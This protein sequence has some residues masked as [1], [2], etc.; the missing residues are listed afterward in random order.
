MGPRS[1]T[2]GPEQRQSPGGRQMA[3][4]EP[5]LAPCPGL[6]A[7]M[8][9]RRQVSAHVLPRWP[10]TSSSVLL[11]LESGMT[12]EDICIVHYCEAAEDG[13][14]SSRVSLA[15]LVLLVQQPVLNGQGAPRSPKVAWVLP[16]T[17]LGLQRFRGAW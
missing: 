13:L 15:S 17:Q 3:A 10:G 1:H 5:V 8:G 9:L 11:Q 12:L 16:Q 7:L 2:Q 14:G 4:S 6:G